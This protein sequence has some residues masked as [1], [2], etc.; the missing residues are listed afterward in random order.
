MV[1]RWNHSHYD[2][3]VIY[4][5]SC[6]NHSSAN[7][8]LSRRWTAQQSYQGNVK[9]AADF[10]KYLGIIAFLIFVYLVVVHG[11]GA[12]SVIN[13][14]SGANTNAILALQG[15]TPSSSF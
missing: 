1:C 4:A 3:R 9:M 2:I 14:L 5:E 8:G 12:K 6:G 7:R 10:L 11:E 15:R 13:A